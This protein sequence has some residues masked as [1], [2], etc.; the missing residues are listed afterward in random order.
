MPILPKVIETSEIVS[1][2]K[3]DIFCHLHKVKIAVLVGY[4]TLLILM[5]MT[6]LK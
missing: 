6:T 3:G 4:I 2:A 1:R 5:I